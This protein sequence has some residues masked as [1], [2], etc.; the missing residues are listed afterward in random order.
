MKRRRIIQCVLLAMILAG[1]THLWREHV[2]PPA[3][4]LE[5]LADEPLHEMFG[6]GVRHDRPLEL[7]LAQGTTIRGLKVPSL[8]GRVGEPGPDGQPQVLNGFEAARVFITHDP[9]ALAAGR[10]RPLTIEIDDAR[11][12]THETEGGIAADFPL[13]LSSD[14]GGVMPRITFRNALLLY[15]A[16]PGSKRLAEGSVLQ[17]LVEELDLNPDAEGR[18]EIRGRMRTRE[19]GQDDGVI[20]VEGALEADGEA[21]DLTA[22]WDPLLL[23]EELLGMLAEDLAA[24]LRTRSIRDGTLVLRLK[25]EGGVAEG[26]VDLRVDWNSEVELGKTVTDLPGFDQV[27]VRTREQLKE[28]LGTGAFQVEFGEGRLNLKSLVTEMAGGQVT[29]TGWVVGETGEFHIEFEIRDLRLEDPAVRRALGE[30]GSALLD[31]F[32]PSG[33]VD[34]AGRVTRSADGEVK[35][36]VDVFVEDVDLRYVGTPGPSGKLEGFPYR[37]YDATGRVRIR[38]EGVEFDDIVGFNRGAEVTILGHGRKGWRGEETGRI[39]FTEDGTR[40]SMSVVATN[41]PVD[42]QLI[43]AI[44]GS[45]FSDMLDEYEIK[46]VIDKVEVDLTKE[47]TLEQSAKG[48]LR[49]TVE[50]EEFRYLPFP[51]PMEDVRGQLT[52][53]R[54]FVGKERGRTYEFDLT[55]WSEGAPVNISAKIAEHEGRGRL[56]VRADGLPLAGTVTETVLS[57][58]MTS[59]DLAPVWRWLGPRGKAKVHVDVPLSDDPGPL[60]LEAEL[61]SAS[62]R[63]NAPSDAP[64]EISKLTGDLTVND[65][66]VTLTNLRGLLGGARVALGGTLRGGVEGVWDVDAEIEP[67]R[68]TPSLLDSLGA[69]TPEGKLLPGGMRFESGSRMALSLQLHKEAGEDADPSIAFTATGLD[70]RIRMPDGSALGLSGASLSV[71]G[72]VVTAKD[73]QA[74][75]EGLTARIPHARVVPGED[76]SITGRFELAFD[77]YVLS[78]GLLDLLPESTVDVLSTWTE[79]RSLRSRSFVVDV[80]E[81]GAVTLRGDLA[82]I[83]PKDGPVGEAARGG[84][85]LRP[86]VIRDEGDRGVVLQ[87]LVQLTGF[88]IDVGVELQHLNGLIEIEHLRVG[89]AGEGRGRIQDIDGR[90]AGLSVSKLSAPVDWTNDVL[91]IPAISGVL[92]GGELVADLVMHTA[93]P[94]AYQGSATVR[95]FDVALLRNDLAPTGPAYAGR[96]TARVTFQ[97]RGGTSRDLTAAGFVQIRSAQ[98][99]DLPIV[100]NVFVLTDSLF[101]VQE[102]PQFQRAD[103]VFTLEKEVFTFSRLDLAGPLFEMPGKGTLDLNGIV[104]LR[105]T[106]DFIKGMLVPG[107]MQ[108]PGIG[109]F[110]RATLREEALYGVRVH[111][112]LGSTRT[113]V[114][115]FPL[116]GYERG[117][118]FEGT[119]GRELPRR[120]LPG[121]FR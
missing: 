103:A 75:T 7:D 118:D 25:R 71:D 48:E 58:E 86:L 73:I 111:G 80:P 81:Q 83:A 46:G 4:A 109:P 36:S 14:E 66:T 95:N 24:P 61:Q 106:P 32:D 59:E 3:D 78:Q 56:H 9:L 76:T 57:A 69:L 99:G 47:P 5:Q 50:G 120:R 54:P 41:V 121:W 21:F 19:L 92:V 112:D 13:E 87:G 94:V 119:G 113:E 8:D 17:V 39:A 11:I 22:R 108:V 67:L 26:A 85:V 116:F 29:A 63:L 27:D 117:S 53:R 88:T 90:I 31:E 82:L 42:D 45:D 40:L 38:P 52:M 74:Q 12:V 65:G 33:V 102:R 98:L 6:P 64:L 115:P 89:A 101:G 1:S 35:W 114:I 93:E 72:G 62:I 23:T 104:D 30:E 68:L 28:L 34:A 105:F 84:F 70:T 18:V 16:M 10:F 60:R 110:L 37:V 91:R 77:D 20:T 15:R 49:I 100:A 2:R 44:Q 51:L 107:V 79:N 43:E 96:G 55:G 97:N